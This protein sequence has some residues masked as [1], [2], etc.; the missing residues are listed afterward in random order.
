MR[1]MDG[2]KGN[3]PLGV[4][5]KGEGVQG[6]SGYKISGQPDQTPATAPAKVEEPKTKKSDTTQSSTR[7]SVS[8]VRTNNTALPVAKAVKVDYNP[9]TVRPW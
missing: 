8:S 2:L 1:G 3:S 9:E 4:E 6:Q 5:P 7:G